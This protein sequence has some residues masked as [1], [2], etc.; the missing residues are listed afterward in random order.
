MRTPSDRLRLSGAKVA[1]ELDE[2]EV[3]VEVEG[4]HFEGNAD[5]GKLREKECAGEEEANS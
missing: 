5:L 3:E 2:V 4:A 1:E